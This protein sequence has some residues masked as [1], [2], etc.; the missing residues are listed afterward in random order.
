MPARRAKPATAAYLERAAIAYLE[1][2]GGTTE[3]LRRVLEKRVARSVEELGTDPREGARALEQ[4]LEKLA[5]MGYV[6]DARFAASRVRTMRARGNSARALRA[7]LARQ[8]LDAALIERA[9]EGDPSD[10]LEAARALV[11][12]RR[13]GPHRPP[14]Q[15]EAERARDLA[16]LARAGFSY[17]VAS[18]ALRGEDD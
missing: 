1:R 4:V 13:L 10:D 2:F 5:R 11:R 14:E 12:R 7:T 16:K 6:D 17:D 9:L 15:R 8:G 18:R 3:R